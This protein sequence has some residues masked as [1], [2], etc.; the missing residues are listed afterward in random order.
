[1]RIQEVY[2]KD[3]IREEIIKELVEDLRRRRMMKE[4][5][6]HAVDKMRAAAD[7]DDHRKE[8]SKG[9]EHVRLV[10]LPTDVGVRRR[11]MTARDV[12]A[13]DTSAQSSFSSSHASSSVSASAATDPEDKWMRREEEEHLQHLG[14]REQIK[15]QHLGYFWSQIRWILDVAG[16]VA[17]MVGVL[18][19]L[20]GTLQLKVPPP[21]VPTQSRI[22]ARP[23]VS[24][25]III[26]P[27]S[28]LR[29]R[30]TRTGTIAPYWTLTAQEEYQ[31]VTAA[32]NTGGA[33]FIA[34]S[35][36]YLVST[37]ESFLALRWH[38]RSF[39]WCVCWLNLIGSILYLLG[40]AI[41]VN[42]INS[43]I[44]IADW[45]PIFIGFTIGSVIFVVAAYLMIVEMAN[46]T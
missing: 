8:Q 14:R 36:F 21:R 41:V 7:G 13:R 40:S 31:W 9:K 27:T 45:L 32:F 28:F 46:S 19:Y 10:H 23:P 24:L 22:D 29:A 35:Y 1:M 39:A 44:L 42:T 38:P 2:K 3:E 26:C 11:V 34:G 5:L 15:L 12:E 30:T 6:H 43:T 4:K 33:A 25:T 18:C 16:A 20:I 17:F 37:T